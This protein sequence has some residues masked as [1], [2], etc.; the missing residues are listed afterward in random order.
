M[1]KIKPDD[2][3]KIGNEQ[4][5]Q[6]ATAL[7][8]NDLRSVEKLKYVDEAIN[9]SEE[10]L[11]EKIQHLSQTVKDKEKELQEMTDELQFL[12]L[13]LQQQKVPKALKSMTLGELREHCSK[14]RL[15]MG[16]YM[17]PEST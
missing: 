9:I 10:K 3:N 15:I 11:G 6:L 7:M 1:S 13:T 16:N 14:F 2:L 5:R 12:N 17:N 8:A 4:I